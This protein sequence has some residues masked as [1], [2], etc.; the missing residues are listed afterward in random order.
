MQYPEFEHATEAISQNACR[1]INEYA[2]NIQSE[3]PYKAQYLLEEVIKNLQER[4]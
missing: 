1:L 3:M 2:K 4:V